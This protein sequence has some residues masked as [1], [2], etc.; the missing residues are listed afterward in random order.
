LLKGYKKDD[1]I[2]I[3]DAIFIRNGDEH[4]VQFNSEDFRFFEECSDDKYSCVGWWHSHP[5]HGIFLSQI[6][7]ENHFISFQRRNPSSIALVIDPTKPNNDGT[8]LFTIFQV[9]GNQSSLKEARINHRVRKEE[10]VYEL[11]GE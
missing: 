4:S 9:E 2:F 3:V 11:E 10:L 7:L 6:D 1:Q 5:G 8:A